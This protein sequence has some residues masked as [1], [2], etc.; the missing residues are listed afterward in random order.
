[1]KRILIVDDDAICNFLMA[2]L[3]EKT[4]EKNEIHSALNGEE[5]L[6]AINQSWQTLHR[7]PDLIFLDL[8]MPLMDGFGFLE[9]YNTLNFDGKKSLIVVVTSSSD[10]KDMERA[11]QLGISHYLTKPLSVHQVQEI[12]SWK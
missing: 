10:E 1:M 4:G 3:L 11:R 6:Q 8:N 5:A 7:L 2:K 12:L 9:V